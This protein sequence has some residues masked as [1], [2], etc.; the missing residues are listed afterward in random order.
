[1]PNTDNFV[2]CYRHP[3]FSRQQNLQVGTVSVLLTRLCNAN[4][5]TRIR[6]ALVQPNGHVFNYFEGTANQILG[7]NRTLN[8]RAGTTLVFD[9]VELFVQP[10]FVDYLRSGWQLSLVA[11]I[12]YTASNGEPSSSNSLHFCAPG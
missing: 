5:D 2:T 11:A 6:F 4:K 10:S 3:T 12:D 9:R 8:G 1:M 7:D